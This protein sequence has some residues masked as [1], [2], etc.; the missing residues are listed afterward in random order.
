MQEKI[1]ITSADVGQLIVDGSI[2]ADQIMIT[3]GDTASVNL[4]FE[5]ALRAARDG[6]SIAR[7]GW[8]GKGMYVFLADGGTFTVKGSVMGD[9]APHLVMKTA[10]DKFVPWLASQTDLVATDWE[11]V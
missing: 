10:D 1:E 9:L 8:N 3:G 7:A 11:I 5:W 6:M 2:N 4:P